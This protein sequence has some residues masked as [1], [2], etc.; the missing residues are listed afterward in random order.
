MMMIDQGI[1][2][3]AFLSFSNGKGSFYIVSYEFMEK[4]LVLEPD[5]IKEVK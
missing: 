5:T 4:M 1:S 3:D 2:P